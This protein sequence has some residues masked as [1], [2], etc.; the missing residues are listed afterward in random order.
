[1]LILVLSIAGS[2]LPNILL[3]SHVSSPSVTS[4]SLLAMDTDQMLQAKNGGVTNMF[5]P[6]HSSIET[7]PSKVVK[8]LTPK[9]VITPKGVDFRPAKLEKTT[10]QEVSKTLEEFKSLKKLTL[11]HVVKARWYNRK[12]DR[13]RLAN[14]VEIKNYVGTMKQNSLIKDFLLKKIKITD[15]VEPKSIQNIEADQQLARSIKQL[16]VHKAVKYR[17]YI[18]EI[19]RE[20]IATELGI[21]Q[22]VGTRE[23]NLLIKKYL[24]ERITMKERW[25]N[26]KQ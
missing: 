16:P 7:K 11:P 15:R 25:S 20:K 6:L 14:E 23:Q 4:V 22:Y 8:K 26:T 17:W 12:T 3:A 21:K 2:L 10:T 18:W 19:D 9:K 13:T 5:N 1:M 24:Q